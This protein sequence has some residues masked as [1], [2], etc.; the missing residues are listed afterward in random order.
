MTRTGARNKDEDGHVDRDGGRNGNRDGEEE[1]GG[2]GRGGEGRGSPGYLPRDGKGRVG[3]TPR[4]EKLAPT[5]NQ[6]PQPQ[7]P[8]PR[9]CRRVVRK[10]RARAQGREEARDRVGGQGR[11]GVKNRKKV[12]KM[13]RLVRDEMWK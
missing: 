7:R 11:G 6:Q 5:C 4:K 9:R 10:R 1:G 3:R 8:T 2:E 13:I 12:Q